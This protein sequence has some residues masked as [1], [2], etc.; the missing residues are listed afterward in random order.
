MCVWWWTLLVSTLF[1][2]LFR[3]YDQTPIFAT[4]YMIGLFWDNSKTK[5]NTRD[6]LYIPSKKDPTTEQRHRQA[7][8]HHRHH[9]RP[10]NTLVH[11]KHR[12]DSIFGLW[13]IS[14]ISSNHHVSKQWFRSWSNEGA[15]GQLSFLPNQ[16]I[17]N[18]RQWKQGS[19]WYVKVL[20][21][22]SISLSYRSICHHYSLK[23]LYDEW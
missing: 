13:A 6:E 14:K 5:Q 1:P 4:P 7:E 11:T 12:C 10:T 8:V 3:V 21:S 9:F 20:V 18:D 2:P 22:L 19:T 23:R 15:I 16:F 17:V